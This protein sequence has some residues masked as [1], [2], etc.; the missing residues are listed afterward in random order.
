MAV[1]G[2]D[3]ES[4]LIDTVCERIR[5]RLPAEQVAPCEAFVRQY[6]Q[7]VPAEDLA[8]RNPLDLYGAAVAH[9]NLAQQR[10]PGE[11]K[12][13]VYNPDFEQ[14]GWQSPHTVIEIVSDDMPFIVD[15]V[16]MDIT[17]KGFG[18]HL[19]IHP[20]MR[21]R[22]DEDGQI[23]DVLDPDSDNSG[24]G[25]ESIF[26]AEVG[27]EHDRAVLDRLSRSI[28]NVLDQVRAATED[29]QA[30]RA[31]AIA[32][33]EEFDEHSP[34]VDDAVAAETKAFLNWLAND[35]F[36]FL[37]YR[38]YDLEQDGSD[39]VLKAVDGSGLGILRGVS[40]K[41][42]KKLSAKTIAY[43]REPQIL[44]LTKANSASPVHRPAYLDYIGVKKYAEDGTMTG[45][46]RFLGLYTTSAYKASPRSIPIIRGKVQGVIQHAGFP[47]ASHDRKA[48]EEI[49]ES[50]PR[51]SLFQM[52][53]EEL[54]NVA[55]GILGL[56]ERQRLRLFMWRDPLDRF[57][58][59][60]VVHPARPLQ[61]REPGTRGPDPARRTARRR[62]RLDPAA[63]RV[64]P[65]ARALH[66]P[67]RRGALGR[68]RRVDDRGASHPGRSRLDRRPARRAGRGPR[69]G[70]RDQAVQALRARLPARLPGRLGGA[71][72]GGRH[73]PDRGA[74]RR[75]RTDDQP[76]PAARGARGHRA[77]QAVQ[78]RRC[79][80]VRRP[81]RRS[82]IW[83]R[84]WPTSAPTRSRPPTG[85]RPG[86]T[87][88]ASRPT[89]RTSSGSATCST[90]R[91]SGCGGASSRTTASTGWC[92][93]PR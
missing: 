12:V 51:D 85:S 65:R 71:L 44:L 27:R 13:R 79:A 72:G 24:A 74:G 17:R 86:S 5:E 31:R 88:S 33:T 1:K 8:D 48:L 62:A 83:A 6:Y 4:E 47:P 58:E 26:H 68:L 78:L 56:G 20:V 16:T 14:H 76:L 63:Q 60:L 92:S 73:R 90:T 64:A 67:L 54:F 37:G 36:T 43:G 3:L 81:A 38:E 91:S 89:P 53:T 80:A 34:P 66:H 10:A 25:S 42:P 46:R 40:S 29:W 41:P 70:G 21:I 15:S 75:R 55:I 61:H 23:V 22:R 7:W 69:R 11:A 2:A 9:W 87:T 30:M 84:R 39:A 50:Y 35:N 52:E 82:S 19:V 32:L 18:I 93:P 45:E 49:L 59:C 77:P 57:V 28:E